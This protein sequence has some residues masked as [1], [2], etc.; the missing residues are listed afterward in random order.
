MDKLN[1]RKAKKNLLD[2]VLNWIK[3]NEDTAK[4]EFKE[5][6]KEVLDKLKLINKEINK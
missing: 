4:E 3:E 6:A 5:S 2:E 1:K